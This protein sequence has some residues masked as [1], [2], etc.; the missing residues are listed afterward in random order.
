MIQPRGGLLSYPALY[1]T[2]AEADS[3]PVIKAVCSNTPMSAGYLPRQW[4][5]DFALELD[6]NK[7]AKD[8]EEMCARIGADWTVL[9][10][11]LDAADF[12]AEPFYVF[13]H[14][15]PCLP[16]MAEDEFG[17]VV[18]QC[19][20]GWHKRLL[21]NT[22]AIN[23]TH[24]FFRFISSVWLMSCLSSRRWGFANY[25][26]V[27]ADLVSWSKNN[28][29]KGWLWARLCR[30]SLIAFLMGITEIDPIRF[31]LIFERFINPSRLDLPD[32]DLDYQS[33]KRDKVIEYLRARHGDDR[34]AGISN[35][36]TLASASA[37][38][39]TGRVFGLTPL[40]MTATKL[41]PKKRHFF[42]AF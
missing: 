32:V 37:F 8:L 24:R 30:G 27:V 11:G 13:E 26:L 19:T 21:K 22:W 9:Q 33:S 12:N 31:N 2:I 18:R 39:D 10:K 1:Q 34:V 28:G 17:E 41:V 23:R 4:V 42:D 15:A 14:H 7:T 16:K 40:N 5:Q 29:V 20:A 6:P 36:T 25:F 3:I 38:R 35:Y